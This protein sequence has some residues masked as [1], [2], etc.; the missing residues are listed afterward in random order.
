MSKVQIINKP[1][2]HILLIVAIGLLVYSNTFHVPFHFDDEF[3]IVKNPIINNLNFFIEPSKAKVF[4]D[5]SGYSTFKLRYIG[6]LTFALNYKLHGLD[7]RGYHIF[8]LTIH[9][10]NAILVYWLVVLTFKTPY[11][12]AHSSSFIVHNKRLISHEQPTMSY[13]PAILIALFSALIFVSHPVQTQA[14]T[15]IWQRVT[16]LATMFYL[17]SLVMYI[18]ARLGVKA[19]VRFFSASTLTFYFIS[20]V[21]AILAMKTKEIAITLPIIITLYEFMFFQEK[22]KRRLLFLTSHIFT[23]L[24]IPLTLVGAGKLIGDLINTVSATTKILTT[25]SRWDYLF[26]QLR[27]IVTYIRLLFLPINQNLDYDYPIYNSFMDPNVFLSFLFL[28]LIF[29]FGI[30]LLYR[31]RVK[32]VHS[33]WSV[34]YSNK[35]LT[36]SHELSAT[37]YEPRTM[38]YSRLISFGIFWFFIALSVESIAIP[39]SPYL[40]MESLLMAG[41]SPVIVDVILEHRVYLPAFGML[42]AVVTAVFIGLN[43]LKG[44]WP[45]TEKVVIS[46][47]ALIIIIFSSATYARNAVW[48]DE[49][50]LWEDVAK[51]SPNKARAHNNLAKGYSGKGW[52]DKSIEHYQIALRLKPEFEEAYG[53]LG[54]IFYFY[55]GLPDKAIRYYQIAL[56]LNPNNAATHLN[57]AIAYKAKGW[58]DKAMEHYRIAKK[59]RPSLYSDKNL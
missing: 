31:S 8:N 18:K 26:T 44:R 45:W 15:Y 22:I 33:S 34:A 7:V 53:N 12:K 5:I 19:K 54:F 58:N 48:Q 39:M 40:M 51:K 50:S 23:I 56:L 38:S 16:S 1:V 28:L 32:K 27:V 6:Y 35:L 41:G 10:L 21:S 36:M 57:L 47:I 13:E 37:S 49:V 17:L 4:T 11:F 3:F 2:V 55:K 29:G 20:L 25:M 42:T 46:M 52:A 9:I 30:Y 43:K 24:I 14:V 59:L